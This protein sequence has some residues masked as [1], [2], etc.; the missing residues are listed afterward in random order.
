MDGLGRKHEVEWVRE[1]V[2]ALIIG[3][4]GMRLERFAGFMIEEFP[5]RTI[6]ELRFDEEA[7][8][9]S[10]EVLA[11]DDLADEEDLRLVVGL[12]ATPHAHFVAVEDFADL[13]VDFS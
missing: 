8:V 10:G 11:A 5:V 9:S 6:L 12:L 3:V 13:L 7:I 4:G 2:E 1:D